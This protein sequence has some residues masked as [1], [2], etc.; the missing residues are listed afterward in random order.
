RA[1]HMPRRAVKAVDPR[2]VAHEI[3]VRVETTDAFADVLLGDR[4]RGATLGARDTGLV[5]R[6]VYGA[7]AWQAR[8]HHPPPRLFNTPPRPPPPSRPALRLGLYQLAF[9]ARVPASAAVDAS[10]RLAGR[11]AGGLVNAVLRRAAADPAALPDLPADSIARLAIE[12]SHP[13]WLVAL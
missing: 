4:L 11:R 9:L 3:L 1:R 2:G 12:W 10:V 5:T 8:L 7:L 13:E 6:L